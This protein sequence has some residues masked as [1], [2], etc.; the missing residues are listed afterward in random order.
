MIIKKSEIKKKL[1]LILELKNN[2]IEDSE[3]LKVME[4]VD[5]KIFIEESLQ[6]KSYENIALPIDCGQTISQ[7]IIVALMTQYLEIKKN[8]RILEIGTGS[9]YQTFILSKLARFVYTVERHKY[10][11]LKAYNLFKTLTVPNI[12]CKHGDG[13]LGWKDQ[14][15][16][17]RIIVTA[18]AQDIPGKLVEQLSNNGKMIVPI[19][20]QHDDQILKKISKID[21]ELIIEDLVNVRFVPL[22]EGK[23]NK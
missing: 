16:F 3:V 8:M 18:C 10:L 13:G 17:D 9:G 2:G 15:P 12:F 5:R 7:P 1:N 22:I 19:G 6:K 14:A 21:N 20:E 11:S 4:E 23:E